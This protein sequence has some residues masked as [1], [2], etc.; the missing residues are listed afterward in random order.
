MGVVFHDA[1]ACDIRNIQIALVIDTDAKWRRKMALRSDA[2]RSKECSIGEK[3][4]DASALRVGHV[5]SA[6]TIRGNS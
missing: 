6:A 4:Q 5:N 3:N 1:R 2:Y